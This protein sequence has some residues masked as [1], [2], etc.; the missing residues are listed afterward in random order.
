MK[1]NVQAGGHEWGPGGRAPGH[2]GAN[3]LLGS[4]GLRSPDADEHDNMKWKK[5]QAGGRKVVAAMLAH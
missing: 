1:V 3:S 5:N 4:G 2:P